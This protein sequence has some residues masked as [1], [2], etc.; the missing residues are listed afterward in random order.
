MHPKRSEKSGRYFI[1][2]KCDP[3]YGLSLETCGRECD[4]VT[5]RSASRNAT[6][7]DLMEEPRSA[8]RVNWP[9]DSLLG[10]RL[11]DELLGEHSGLAMRHHPA[12]DVAAEDVED[13]VEVVV[14]PLLWSEQFRDVPGPQLVGFGGQELGLGVVWTAQLVTTLADFTVGRQQA[15]HRALRGQ[16][17]PF[18]E[19]RGVHLGGRV[20]HEAFGTEFVQHCR[21]LRA[22]EG[23]V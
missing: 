12:D 13:D 17:C 23:P 16:V 10:Q 1:V 20:V 2:L 8:C 14:R 22:G 7:F 19:Q 5:P 9:R 4:F 11:A 18:V 21:S 15:V 3:E 6:D